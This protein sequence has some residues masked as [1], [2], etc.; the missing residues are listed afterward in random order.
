[1]T[2]WLFTTPQGYHTG[3]HVHRSP[4]VRSPALFAGLTCPHDLPRLA[5]ILADHLN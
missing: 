4:P 5:C 1:L 3:Y 2:F